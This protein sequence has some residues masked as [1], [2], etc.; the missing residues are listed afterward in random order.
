MSE[1]SERFFGVAQQH[2]GAK[3]AGEQVQ[4]FPFYPRI[5]RHND[6]SHVADV[7]PQRYI[8]L[9]GQAG[10]EFVLDHIR[11]RYTSIVCVVVM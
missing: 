10:D 2:R 4:I 3:Y 1:K 5:V 11:R 7:V 8:D 6:L 9:H